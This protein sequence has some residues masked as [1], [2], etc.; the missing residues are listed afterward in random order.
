VKRFRK[1]NNQNGAAMVEFAIVLPL[2]LTLIFG[3]IEFG[4]MFYDKAV[5]TNASR[6]AA[7]VGIMYTS[8]VIQPSFTKAERDDVI[9]D[10]VINYSESHLITFGVS[11]P[12]TIS[13]AGDCTDTKGRTNAGKPLT[14]SVTFR[15]TFL[16]LPNF[17]SSLIGP[18]NISAE[19]VM[20]C[21]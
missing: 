13:L 18:I 4:V 12:P 6:E 10:T 20:R 9:T 5:I 15:Y 1:I 21:E 14:V 17:I 2:L 19:T 8:S 7:R 11:S 16:V 3:I